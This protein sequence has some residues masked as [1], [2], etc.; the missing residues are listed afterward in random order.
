MP[1]SLA[2]SSNSQDPLKNSPYWLLYISLYI[3]QELG[4]GLR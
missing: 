4:T 2:Q 1:A 3:R